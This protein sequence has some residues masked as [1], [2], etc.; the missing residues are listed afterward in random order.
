VFSFLQLN[1]TVKSSSSDLKSHKLAR[2]VPNLTDIG[3]KQ[4]KKLK[5]DVRLFPKKLLSATYF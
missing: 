5:S 2:S 1:F 3:L 4:E